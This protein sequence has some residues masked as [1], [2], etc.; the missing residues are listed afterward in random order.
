MSCIQPFHLSS[1][2]VGGWGLRGIRV[3][4][5]ELGGAGGWER[6]W[7]FG[8]GASFEPGILRFLH[9]LSLVISAR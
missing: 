6:G 8:G 9:L 4:G 2:W 3:G 7:D 5:E 1:V